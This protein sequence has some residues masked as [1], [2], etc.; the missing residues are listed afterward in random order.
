MIGKSRAAIG[1]VS[2]WDKKIPLQE[3][4]GLPQRDLRTG[5][6]GDPEPPP[7]Q[8]YLLS[9]FT[10]STIRPKVEFVT[11]ANEAYHAAIAV[12]MPM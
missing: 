4:F 11:A 8:N 6:G 12:A 1:F 10:G 9:S 3:G 2:A 7:F 5:V